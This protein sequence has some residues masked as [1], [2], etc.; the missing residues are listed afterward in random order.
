V[1][2]RSFTVTNNECGT[3]E[4]TADGR[5][6]GSTVTVTGV[7]D[8]SDTCYSAKLDGV[9]VEDGQLDLTVVTYVPPENEGNA[10]GE[11]IVD[12]S[13]EAIV[14]FDGRPPDS[15]VVHHDDEQVAEF[16]LG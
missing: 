16:G 7:V 11:C 12:I 13:Y 10:C 4:N 9:S 1:A 8:G 15:C 5:L 6:D 2:S 3:G 14:E